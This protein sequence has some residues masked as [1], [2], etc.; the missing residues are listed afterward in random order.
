MAKIIIGTS[1][2]NMAPAFVKQ[3]GS[4]AVI[5]SLSITPTTS[6]QTITAPSGVDGYSPITVS[7][8]SS[9]IDA[10]ITAGNIKDGVTILGV[11]GN[12]TGSSASRFGVTLDNFIG[13]V[14]SNGRLTDIPKMPSI[15]FTGVQT[16]PGYTSFRYS[17][18]Y[19]DFV[20]QATISFPD[21]TTISGYY[22]CYHMFANLNQNV[23]YTA[24]NRTAIEFPNLT[25]INGE[26]ACDGMFYESRQ[27]KSV[28][29]PN[30][31]TISGASA[32]I[33]MFYNCTNLSSV[34][35]PSLVTVSDSGALYDAF[36]YTI[37]TE[38]HFKASARSTITS[39]S[40]YSTKFGASDAT[41]Y[42]DL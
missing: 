5:D 42:F 20:Q 13:N 16:I 34:S 4:S 23:T 37:V 17:L 24:T 21:L 12:Y 26:H 27:I 36:L 35:F 30:L 6:A 8:V 11:T 22:S 2:T 15:T 33:D 1:D 7:A 10:N 32:C 9:S 25:T 40:G 14:D 18:S 19:K 3:V 41:I 31:T 28:S 39:L 38:I 29:F